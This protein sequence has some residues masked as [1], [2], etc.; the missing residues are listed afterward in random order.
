M[1]FPTIQCVLHAPP[2]HPLWLH[3][4]N[5]IWW[6]IQIMKLLLM[7]FS[8]ATFSLLGPNIISTLLQVSKI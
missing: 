6:S 5:N 4:P 8:P 3:R 2:T 7:Q 1:R